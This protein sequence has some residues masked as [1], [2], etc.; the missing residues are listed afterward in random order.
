M[1]YIITDLEATCWENVRAP[2]RMEIIEIGAVALASAT[3][4]VGEFNRFVRPIAE[5][6]LSAFCTQLTSIT[7]ADVDGADIF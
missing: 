6:R 7:Q 3:A 2:E 5:P 1:R 4:V